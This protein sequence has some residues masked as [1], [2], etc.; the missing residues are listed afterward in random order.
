MDEE[1]SIELLKK[2]YE[3]LI[4]YENKPIQPS[5]QEKYWNFI[6]NPEEET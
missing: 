2:K 1:E 5:E 3:E 6:Y 4:L